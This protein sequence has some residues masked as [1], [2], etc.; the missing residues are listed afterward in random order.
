MF[1][2]WAANLA[3]LAGIVGIFL[4]LKGGL[5]EFGIGFPLGAVFGTTVY[6]VAHK[7]AYGSW[8]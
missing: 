4:V 8:F 2:V 7:L 5:G 6:Q 1:I 3:I